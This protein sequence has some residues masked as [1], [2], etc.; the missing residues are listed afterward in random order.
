VLFG[1]LLPSDREGLAHSRWNQGCTH[2]HHAYGQHQPSRP[3]TRLPSSTPKLALLSGNR[4][5][6]V[7]RS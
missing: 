1:G 2:G 4:G 3:T 6:L 7:F 5:I